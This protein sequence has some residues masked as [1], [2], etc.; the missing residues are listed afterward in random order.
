MCVSRQLVHLFVSGI[1]YYILY[2]YI[3]YILYSHLAKLTSAISNS[4]TDGV[5]IEKKILAIFLRPT[6]LLI[7]A[8]K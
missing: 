6:D 4:E 3:Y 8:L 2:I 7:F 5:E 1:E